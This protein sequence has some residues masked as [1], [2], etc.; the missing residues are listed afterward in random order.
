MRS[1]HPAALFVTGSIRSRPALSKRSACGRGVK[2]RGATHRNG[3]SEPSEH[4][5]ETSVSVR[6]S[7]ASVGHPR[8]KASRWGP[9]RAVPGRR[10]RPRVLRTRSSFRWKQS[11]A[12][13]P[14]FRGEPAPRY[15]AARWRNHVRGPR[16]FHT[17]RPRLSHGRGPAQHPSV[18]STRGPTRRESSPRPAALRRSDP[19]RAGGDPAGVVTPTEAGG[20]GAAMSLVL[21]TRRGRIRVR[22]AASSR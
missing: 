18:R 3:D 14:L 22:R 21:C 17:R 19:T 6:P 16:R 9:L 8:F 2:H 15:V 4:G 7:R 20:V 13:N 10:V 12:P 1:T 5:A 11:I